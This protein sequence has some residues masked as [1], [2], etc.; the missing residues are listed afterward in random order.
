MIDIKLLR[1]SPDFI[2]EAVVRKGY[3]I[4]VDEIIE[5]DKRRRGLIQEIEELRRAAKEISSVA[6]RRRRQTAIKA[7][8]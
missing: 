8:I 7:G 1:D 4:D 5:L 2:K 3:K 6:K